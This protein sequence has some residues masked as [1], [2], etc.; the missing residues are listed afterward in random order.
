LKDTGPRHLHL[1]GTQ[2]AA[3][4][5]I[6]KVAELD[7]K[8]VVFLSSTSASIGSV[9]KLAGLADAKGIISTAYLKDPTDPTLN[10]DLDVQRRNAFMDQYLPRGRS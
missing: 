2:R 10:A 5:A 8:P 6:R 4:Q 3:A 1:L 9:L 7:W